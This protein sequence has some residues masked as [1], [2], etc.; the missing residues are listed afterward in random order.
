MVTYLPASPGCPEDI[1][2]FRYNFFS[3][4]M[5]RPEQT[6]QRRIEVFLQ[7]A[8]DGNLK[9]ITRI[10]TTG[11]VDPSLDNNLA[12][13]LA[14]E[15]H[16]NEVAKRLLA[17]P[18]VQPDVYAVFSAINANN[19]PMARWLLQRVR[20]PVYHDLLQIP[21]AK[22]Y[23]EMI[24]LIL[25]D[26][27]HQPTAGNLVEASS[28]NQPEVVKLYLAYPKLNPAGYDNQAL[29]TAVRMNHPAITQLLLHDGR[30]L[31]HLFT[32]KVNQPELQAVIDRMKNIERVYSFVFQGVS[33][34]DTL[35]WPKADEEK[36]ARLLKRKTL[37]QL[38]NSDLPLE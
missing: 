13:R 32:Q 23:L 14:L 8:R 1:L 7:S 12:L 34:V 15:R 9:E 31:R 28:G 19:L 25:Q 10:L 37:I 27:R 36:E 17:D 18:R 21:S 2:E 29:T 20:L 16:H 30:V 22:G 24:D 4:E 3:Q 35:Y 38:I 6:L 11:R 5:S 26:P 33:L